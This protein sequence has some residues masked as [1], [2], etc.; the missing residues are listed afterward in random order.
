M[1]CKTVRRLIDD[2]VDGLLPTGRSERVRAHLERCETCHA[3]SEA[4]RAASTSL[5]VWG[6]LEA[7]A[8]CFD[9]ILD[10]IDQLPAEARDRGPAQPVQFLTARAVKWLATGG[11]AAA[12]A[13]MA[14]VSI[15]MSRE[16]PV[17][18]T[19]RPGLSVS[20]DPHRPTI[21]P[22]G[23]FAPPPGPVFTVPGVI[24][25]PVVESGLRK[26]RVFVKEAAPVFQPDDGAGAD[27]PR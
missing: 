10:R 4:T 20:A 17:R 12:A 23:R 15:E 7:P 13:V 24:A 18:R 1:R 5:A 9:S 25:A 8:G 14:G 3:D 26:R 19:V 22:F 16:A 27:G 2:H 11:M 21:D 6:D